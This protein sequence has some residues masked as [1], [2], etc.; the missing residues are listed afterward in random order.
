MKKNFLIF[1]PIKNTW[2]KKFLNNLLFASESAIL[3]N[4]G[5]QNRYA[6]TYI[7][8]F[9]W[10]N[11]KILNKDFIKLNLIF[12]NFLNIFAIRL[13]K[14]HNTNYSQRTWRLILGPWLSNF[15]H[16]YF[17]R[18][19]N[20][21]NIFLKKKIDRC[22]FLH[23][24]NNLP[25]AYDPKEFRDSI[26]DDYWNQYI[27]QKISINFI[28]KKN[29]LYKKI[30]NKSQIKIFNKAFKFYQNN[31]KKKYFSLK[32]FIVKIF[33]LINR[34]HY[35]YFIFGNN[36]GLINEIKLAWRFKQ[37][38]ILSYKEKKFTKKK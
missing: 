8:P 34:K 3:K 11:K 37:I 27:Y 23:F 4:D 28:N 17:E 9:K 14:I 10:K 21:K 35:K 33:N 7:C 1:T 38:P 31:T 29:I 30:S 22:I 13:N 12:E 36:F 26:Q 25:V 6:S 32:R 24:N 19:S 20:I 5:N 15:I 2:P 16:I 18:Y